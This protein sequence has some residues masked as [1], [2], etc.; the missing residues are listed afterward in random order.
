V[1]PGATFNPARTYLLN[2]GGKAIEEARAE[3][4]AGVS[5]DQMPH[6]LT[7]EEKRLSLQILAR[8]TRNAK[9]RRVN[10]DSTSLIREYRDR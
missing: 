4:H 6:R 10:S 7:D 1:R 9:G 8:I 5:Q 3:N 2:M